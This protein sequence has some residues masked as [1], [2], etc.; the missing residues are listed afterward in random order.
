MSDIS[1]EK[2]YKIEEWCERRRISRAFYYVMKRQ[3]RGPRELRNGR[4][5][6]ITRQADAEWQKARE[7]EQASA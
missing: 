1:V 5:V 3:G 2:D 7:A 4:K 6:T